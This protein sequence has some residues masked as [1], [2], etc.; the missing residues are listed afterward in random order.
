MMDLKTRALNCL[1][2]VVDGLLTEE[3][4]TVRDALRRYLE[5]DHKEQ[6]ERTRVARIEEEARQDTLTQL[7]ATLRKANTLTEYQLIVSRYL[8][9]SRLGTKEAKPTPIR[10]FVGPFVVAG[11]RS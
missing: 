4:A 10:K 3:G 1:F 5:E 6:D 8:A 7:E 11:G 9:A 2:R